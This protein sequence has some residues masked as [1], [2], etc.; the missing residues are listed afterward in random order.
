LKICQRRVRIEEIGV[1]GAEPSLEKLLWGYI[2]MIKRMSM[3]LIALSI[4]LSVIGITMA[5][6]LEYKIHYESCT[7]R[8][9]QVS[10]WSKKND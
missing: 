9:Y 7:N 2:K 6:V 4:I 1:T 8:V 3:L 5:L 10:L